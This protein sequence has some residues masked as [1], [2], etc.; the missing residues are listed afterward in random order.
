MALDPLK[1]PMERLKSLPTGVS[2]RKDPTNNSPFWTEDLQYYSNDCVLSSVDGGAYVM[3]GGFDVPL[4]EALTSV[5]GGDDPA[6]DANGVWTSLA[7][8]GVGKLNWSSTTFTMTPAA[9][10]AVTIGPA[11]SSGS[12]EVAPVAALLEEKWMAVFTAAV[13]GA[14]VS[15]FGESLNVTLQ[16][17][18][19]A[20]PVGAA[21]LLTCHMRSG[22]NGVYASAVVT[23]P[24]TS[25]GAYISATWTAAAQPTSIATPVLTWVRIA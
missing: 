24:A 7:P 14:G 1:N 13:T 19:V 10:N 4:S 8:S 17:V 22:L 23:L 21:I 25:T 20:A 9:A 2:W 11:V 18:A 3:T 5:R 12:L 6:N 16:P 15:L